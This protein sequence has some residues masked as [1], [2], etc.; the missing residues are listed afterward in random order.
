[1]EDHDLKLSHSSADVLFAAPDCVQVLSATGIIRFINSLGLALLGAT[2][3]E[4]VLGKSYVELWPAAMHQELRQALAEAVA[5]Q[6]TRIEGLCSTLKGTWRWWEAHFHGVNGDHAPREI[7]CIARDL[8]DRRACE[9]EMQAANE[10]LTA[11]IADAERRK[12]EFIA[13]LAHELRNPLAP[14]RSG[15][16]VLKESADDRSAVEAARHI[17]ER[18]VAQMVRLI[19][20][21]LDI[22][23]VSSG[24]MELQKSHLD[25]KTVVMEAVATTAPLMNRQMQKLSVTIPDA[26]IGLFADESRLVQV[27]S[28]LLNNASKYTPAGAHIAINVECA[29]ATVSVSVVDAGVGLAEPDMKRVF[30]MFTV[31]GRDAAGLHEGLGIGLSLVRRL[32]EM[33]EGSV[34]AHSEGLG[35]GSRFVVTL[36]ITRAAPATAAT[37]PVKRHLEEIR[38]LLVDDNV[39]AAK[40]LAMLLDHGDHLIRVAESGREALRVVADFKP[41]IVFLDIGMPGMDGYEVA[42][43]VRAM[44]DV[45]N[46]VLVALT[47]WGG[48]RDRERTKEAG[49]DEHLTKPADLASI[50]AMLYKVKE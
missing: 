45:G 22:A 43:A 6:H 12:V 21:L 49:F 11:Q 8:T 24:K 3:S 27:F 14:V 37:S 41:D 32:V 44:P 39:D 20:D 4:E 26:R 34:T 9:L 35:K 40:T 48:Q 23:R 25:L 28:N 10:R 33:H 13:T 47:G 1:V 36:P 15:L 29:D 5:G 19:N 31:V 7:I 30:E 2:S 38:I 18:Q 17:M 50:E 46:T 42:R 16:D